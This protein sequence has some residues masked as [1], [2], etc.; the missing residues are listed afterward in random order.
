MKLSRPIKT[1]QGERSEFELPQ[2]ATLALFR[3]IEMPLEMSDGK[4]IKFALSADMMARFLGNLLQ[5]PP[6]YA[7]RIPLSLTLEV[8]RQAL[9]LLPPE[10]QSLIAAGSATPAT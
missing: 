4:G 8:L 6:S 1:P 5:I 7:E 10:L 3:G 2:E 9:P